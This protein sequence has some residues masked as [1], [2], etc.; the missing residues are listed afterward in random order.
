MTDRRGNVSSISTC[1]RNGT[2]QQSQPPATW[3]MR[4]PVTGKRLN[5]QY[6]RRMTGQ[7]PNQRLAASSLLMS[8]KNWKSFCNHMLVFYRTSQDG[9]PWPKTGYA[10]VLQILYD[11]PHTECHMPIGMQFRRSYERC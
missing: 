10:Q 5:S 9:L 11:Y 6:G 4:F 8:D 2:S 1:C 7:T 3:Q